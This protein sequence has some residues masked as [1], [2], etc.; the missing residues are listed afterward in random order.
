M[1]LSPSSLHLQDGL[2]FVFFDRLFFTTLA[3]C[4]IDCL[5]SFLALTTPLLLKPRLHLFGKLITFRL[6][7]WAYL[8]HSY[9]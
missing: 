2:T 6:S 8:S 7:H 3:F 9:R 1:L 4:F 5:L